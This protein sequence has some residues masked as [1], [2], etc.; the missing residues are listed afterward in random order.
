M[1]IR[2]WTLVELLCGLTLA[3]LLLGI[4]LPAVGK[5]VQGSS[6]EQA[7]IRIQC[8]LRQIRSLSVQSRRRIALAMPGMECPVAGYRRVAFRACYVDVDYHFEDWVGGLGWELL[9]S[10]TCIAAISMSKNPLATDNCR[11]VEV[12]WR[13]DSGESCRAPCRVV[14][15]KPNGRLASLQQYLCFAVEKNGIPDPN[16]PRRLLRIDQYAGNVKVE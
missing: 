9:P 4:S 6:Q 8:R 16:G 7:T 14:V 12:P 13:L 3:L 5:W 10:G 15:Y 11:M 2:R 1:K